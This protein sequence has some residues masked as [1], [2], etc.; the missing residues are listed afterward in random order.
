MNYLSTSTVSKFYVIVINYN[1]IFIINYKIISELPTKKKKDNLQKLIF[2]PWLE[3]HMSTSS[4]NFHL[5][6]ILISNE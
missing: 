5:K 2:D 3:L 6:L 1:I 4:M